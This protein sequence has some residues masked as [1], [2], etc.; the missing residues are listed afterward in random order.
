M[1]LAIAIYYEY[2][3]LS[4]SWAILN[5]LLEQIHQCDTNFNILTQSIALYMYLN[6]YT[7]LTSQCFN[8][9]LALCRL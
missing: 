8:I 9:H 5:Q 6:G 4:S 3:P 2:A 1:A 7:D